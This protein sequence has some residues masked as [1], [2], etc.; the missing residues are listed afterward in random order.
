[1]RTIYKYS[2]VF[3][4]QATRQQE[5]LLVMLVPL[6]AVLLYALWGATLLH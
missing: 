5:T 3:G 4:R 6:V 2:K 1:M